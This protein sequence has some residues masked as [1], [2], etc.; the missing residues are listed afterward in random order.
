M[1]TRRTVTVRIK[2]MEEFDKE[3]LENTLKALRG[4]TVLYEIRHDGSTRE[5]GKKKLV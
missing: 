4:E 5:L 2:R 3:T 1:A